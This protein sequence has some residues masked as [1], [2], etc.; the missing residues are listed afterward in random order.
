MIRNGKSCQAQLDDAAD[1]KKSRAA[2]IVIAIVSTG[3]WE[4]PRFL[5]TTS[6]MSQD[7]MSGG[8][9]GSD[10]RAIQRENEK[11]Q[12]L[13]TMMTNQLFMPMHI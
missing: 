4:F 12:P 2:T 6:R 11:M 13:N 5:V 8:E 10:G 1:A 3:A 7:G 9:I